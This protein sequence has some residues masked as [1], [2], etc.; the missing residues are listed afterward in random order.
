M[1]HAEPRQTRRIRF[2]NPRSPLSTIVIP[3]VIQ[4]MT[5]GRKA[6]FAPLNLTICAALVP[7]DWSVEIVDECAMDQPHQ[8]RADVDL[9]GIGA[10]TTQSARAY[11]IADAYRRLGIT[12]VMGGIHPSALPDEALQHADAVAIGD[13]ES[14]L[15]H[16]L[17]D[18]EAGQL[19][20]KYHWQELGTAEITTPRKDLLNPKDYLTFHPIQTTRGCPHNCSFC[21][22]P[23]I[24]GRKF[25][26]RPM[27]KIVEEIREAKEV[28]G[29][30]FFIFSDDNFAGN[31]EWALELCQRLIPLKINW[32]SQ[33]DILISQSDK[34]LAAMRASG[35]VGLIL[36]LES[37][38]GETL[39]EAGKRFVKADSYLWRIK[40]ISSHRISLWGAFIFGFD[41]DTWETCRDTCRFAQ[42]ADLAM[43]CF[44]IL[45]PY[46]GTQMHQRFAAEG[47]IR[48]RDWLKYNGA[49]VV[50]DPKNFTTQELRH[51][52]MSAFCEFYHPRSAMARLKAWPFK[53]RAWM[54]NLAAYF[55]LW[56][57]LTGRN[58]RI[59][60]FADF[61]DRTS[62]AWNYHEPPAEPAIESVG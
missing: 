35:C 51:A 1:I 18:F 38:R 49:G 26:Q 46:P 16:V 48:T 28:H 54:A 19:K 42:K 8:A 11:E 32:A 30:N 27:D 39:A 29:A 57:Y 58:R 5:M 61:Q 36:G 15:P 62:L 22:T 60:R 9:V 25:R 53:K 4:R 24:F 40:K 23:A 45:T 10:M 17:A 20:R 33:C 2:I 7:R 47:R 6:L 56:Y 37:V 34:L 59:P 13:A 12:V 21:T 43:A 31:R 50:Y 44:P 41:H 55:G 52:Q 3:G 14:T